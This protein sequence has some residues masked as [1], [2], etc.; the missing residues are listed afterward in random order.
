MRLA[1]PI[2]DV[3]AL[4]AGSAAIGRTGRA[5]T[6]PISPAMGTGPPADLASPRPRYRSLFPARLLSETHR[7]STSWLWLPVDLMAAVPIV[8]LR[9]TC[10]V[11]RPTTGQSHAQPPAQ[12]RGIRL[13]LGLLYD[14]MH[15]PWIARLGCDATQAV[16]AGSRI[17]RHARVPNMPSLAFGLGVDGE[18]C[19]DGLCCVHFGRVARPGNGFRLAGMCPVTASG[20]PACER[21]RRRGSQSGVRL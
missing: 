18:L 6:L 12:I 9:T 2:D 10:T 1:S 7:R 15:G 5:S 3:G 4:P 19:S 20:L 14:A 11:Q 16:H 8:A 17:D 21:L 13:G